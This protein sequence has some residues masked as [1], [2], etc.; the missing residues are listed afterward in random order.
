MKKKLITIIILLILIA[1]ATIYPFSL[2]NLYSLDEIWN[3]GFAKS[4]LDGLIPYK[5]FSM[6]IPP[7]FPY[8]TSIILAIFGEKIFIYYAFIAVITVTI[9]Y[10]AYKKI[11]YNAILIYLLLLVYSSNGYNTITLFFLIIILTLIDNKAKKQDVLIPLLVSL[12]VLSKQTMALLI[13]PS[14]LYSKNKKKSFFVYIICFLLFLVYLL[15]NNNLIP[16][17]DYCLLGMFEFTEK[18]GISI[19]IY[20]IIE[21]IVCGLLI[22][23]LI[24]S[25]GKRQDAFYI[26]MYQIVTFPIV[27]VSHFVLAFAPVVYLIFKENHMTKFLR[28]STFIV[29]LTII[30]CILFIGN[31]TTTI[32]TRHLLGYSQSDGFL[33][34]KLVPAVTDTYI[35]K[36][37]EFIERYPE[38]QLYVLGNY[39]YIVKLYLDLPITKYDLINN[40]NMGYQG[41]DRYIEEINQTCQNQ[42]CLFIVKESEINQKDYN[43]TN[44]KILKNVVK[45]YKKIYSSSTFCVYK[46]KEEG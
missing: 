38:D 36:M 9:T 24:K 5:D 7:L 35:E 43:Q 28:I 12:M 27:D 30:I 25:K 32:Q 16:F 6:I 34:K 22:Y 2:T 4:I 45:N 15:V 20:L 14:L 33:E 19:F 1:I 18:N 17:I 29:I 3:Y 21:L 37:R 23:T 46:S 11:G 40:G 8:I 13:I 10:I 39:A 42:A 44:T 26:L 31:Y 41:A